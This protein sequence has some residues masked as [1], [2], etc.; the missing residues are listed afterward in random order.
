MKKIWK[1]LEKL[2]VFLLMNANK[3][4]W[5]AL[6]PFLGVFVCLLGVGFFWVL[7]ASPIVELTKYLINMRKFGKEIKAMLLDEQ[8]K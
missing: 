2:T 5:L 8:K 1:E 3:V 6:I 7:F 4:C